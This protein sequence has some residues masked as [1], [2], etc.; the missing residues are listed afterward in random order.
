M[1]TWFQARH[2]AQADP[3]PPVPQSEYL[4]NFSR[5]HHGYR[6][7]QGHS[8]PAIITTAPTMDVNAPKPTKKKSRIKM[9]GRSRTSTSTSADSGHL[10]M[11]SSLRVIKSEKK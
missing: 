7:D 3:T 4:S 1:L 11:P 8:A 5:L 2:Q 6:T 9:P 10:E